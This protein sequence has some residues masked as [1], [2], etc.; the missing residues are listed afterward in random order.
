MAKIHIHSSIQAQAKIPKRLISNLIP[1]AAVPVLPE[2]PK[3]EIVK[4]T[5]LKKPKKHLFSSRA[6]VFDA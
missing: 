2:I 6:R 4:N 3:I 5:L 1:F